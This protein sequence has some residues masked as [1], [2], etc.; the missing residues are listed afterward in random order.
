MSCPPHTASCPHRSEYAA[1]LRASISARKQRLSASRSK[2]PTLDPGTGQGALI[3]SAPM[4][5]SS[6]ESD[7]EPR[8]PAGAR[9]GECPP[10]RSSTERVRRSGTTCLVSPIL[11]SQTPSPPPIRR[12]QQ[13]CPDL[14]EQTS[15]QSSS[16]FG[17][18]LDAPPKILPGSVEVRSTC[19]FARRNR[20][21]PLAL[22]KSSHWKPTMPPHGD[23][24]G[25]ASLA[26]MTLESVTPTRHDTCDE[27]QMEWSA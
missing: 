2:W 16:M 14:S 24:G 8:Q 9:Q 26:R 15:L 20:Y 13:L 6:D 11:R 1:Q 17:M 23:G 25:S 21:M 18:Q 12:A 3:G 4:A 7:E 19:P 22:R 10:G 5:E 27:R